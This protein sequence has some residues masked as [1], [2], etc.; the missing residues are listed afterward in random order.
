MSTEPV[1][2]IYV[3]GYGRSGSTVVDHVIARSLGVVSGGELTN[4]FAWAAEE[5]E[6]A[7][8][9]PVAVCPVWG[10]A[11]SAAR[12][13]SQLSLTE[14]ARITRTAEID[15]DEGASSAWRVAWSAFFADLSE[16]G[17]TTVVDSSKSAGGRDRVRL[18]AECDHVEITLVV[19]LIRDPRAV[20]FSRRRGNNL[21][22]ERGTAGEN[23]TIGVVKAIVGWW[24]ANALA[25]RQRTLHR[26]VVWR[27]E[28][29]VGDPDGHTDHLARL[30]PDRGA[31][32]TRE[33]TAHA[34]AGNRLARSDWDGA[35]RLDDEWASEISRPW[36]ILGGLLSALRRRT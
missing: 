28:E 20:V 26:S 34:V 24:R 33:Q 16:R 8:A 6:C 36:R 25:D 21:A 5:R 32:R 23:K 27:Y 31:R 9:Q 3:T 29:F 7:C 10:E 17:F 12:R 13:A 15:R 19:H 14:L 2:L 11:I 4:V 18:L 30:V 22:L 1:R 35:I